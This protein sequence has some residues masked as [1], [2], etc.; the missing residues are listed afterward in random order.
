MALICHIK[1]LHTIT[2]VWNVCHSKEMENIHKEKHDRIRSRRAVA[3]IIATLLM[4]AIAVVGG[5]MIYVFTQGF[6]GNSNITNSPS[7]DTITMSGYDMRE[8]VPS[9]CPAITAGI[10]TH[11]GT[12]IC[13]GDVATDDGK[14]DTEAGAIYI[15]NV[16][17][18]SYT[19]SKIEVNGRLLGFVS[20][21][22]TITGAP[23]VYAVYAAEKASDVLISD[24]PATTATILPGQEATVV[25]TFD[26][27]GTDDNTAAAGRT[28]PV[29]M[30]SASGSVFNFNVVVGSKQ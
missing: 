2:Y 13:H 24:V 14:A 5:V 6:F 10:T 19:I 25:V 12:I 15:R 18:K 26:G 29:K 22:L 28:I 20:T 1:K 23:A 16:G 21:D 8:V 4:I 9:V 27:T 30:T 11:E 17:Q 7:V 3:P